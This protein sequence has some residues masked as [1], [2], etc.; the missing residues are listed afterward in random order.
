MVHY[1]RRLVS[2]KS[3]KYLCQTNLLEGKLLVGSTIEPDPES[4]ER[5]EPWPL[6]NKGAL[7]METRPNKLTLK[8]MCVCV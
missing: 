8:T 7:M 6:N 1:P 3:M 2:T 5:T 4:V